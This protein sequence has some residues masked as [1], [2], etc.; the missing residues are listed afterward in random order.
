M[1]RLLIVEDD[2][3]LAQAIQ[4]GLTRP[5]MA[6]DMAIDVA[7]AKR[8][9]HARRYEVVMI[10]RGLPDGD[11]LSLVEY[12]RDNY[13]RTRIIV[14]TAQNTHEERVRGLELGADD[15]LG[16]PISLAECA[17]RVKKM[18]SKEKLPDITQLRAG[19]VILFPEIGVLQIGQKQQLLRPREAAILG[20][21]I[22]HKN[23]VVTRDMII[24]RIWPA[25]AEP[26]TY[27]TIDVYLRRLR[28]L[29]D[30][31]SHLLKTVRGYG[32]MIKDNRWVQTR[33]R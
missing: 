31:H 1:A 33:S 6:V 9:L 5:A 25:D 7:A 14:L 26:P 17:L 19:Q 32:F 8:C 18:L 24:E 2:R 20:V 29:M 13:F 21:L 27:T 4:D 12:I 30:S 16:K 15:Y 23:R 3:H 28:L 22:K 10:D 11:G